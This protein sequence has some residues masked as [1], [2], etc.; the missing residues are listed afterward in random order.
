MIRTTKDHIS[1]M[2][3]HDYWA[4]ERIA[5]TLLQLTW[6]PVKAKE[7]FDHIIAAHANWY[8]RV[9]DQEPHLPIWRSN[10]EVADYGKWLNDFHDKWN[11]ILA[12][13]ADDLDRTIRYKNIAG[14][15]FQ[16]SLHEVLLHLTLHSQYHRGQV[17][18]LVRDVVDETPSTDMIVY[19]R[20][21]GFTG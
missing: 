20:E 13:E 11:V 18:T 9:T 12:N 15:E 10:L 2:M 19:L 7:L 5:Q 3:H 4:N 6:V 21:S 8:A 1:L 16:N 17:I 14:R